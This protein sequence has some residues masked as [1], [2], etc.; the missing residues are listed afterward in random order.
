MT[1][2]EIA[3]KDMRHSFRSAFSL[4]FMFA[5]PLLV[6]GM[7]ALMFGNQITSDTAGPRLMRTAPLWGVRARSRFLHDG[8]A[9]D[10][11]TAIRLHDGQGQGAAAAF[12]GLNPQ[13]RQQLLDFLDTI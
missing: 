8:R 7:M 5:I 2:L 12:Q 3:F 1:T 11:P 9:S 6:T 13:Q 10:L 4:V